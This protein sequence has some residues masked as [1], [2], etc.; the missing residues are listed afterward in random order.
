MKNY[1]ITVDFSD[2][3]ENDDNGN[4][5]FWQENIIITTYNEIDA[6]SIAIDV[7][8]KKF[9]VPAIALFIAHVSTL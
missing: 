3:T 9:N 4:P 5:V 6:R 8:A 2:L 1:K 7:M